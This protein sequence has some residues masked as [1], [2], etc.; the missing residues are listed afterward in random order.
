MRDKTS[1]HFV[2][3]IG[4][5]NTGG[6]GRVALYLACGL[7][8][9]G[10]SATCIS[11]RQG[12]N[13]DGFLELLDLGSRHR[14]IGSFITLGRLISYIRR[15][16]PSVLHVHGPESLVVAALAIIGARHEPQLWFTWHNSEGVFDGSGPRKWLICWAVRRSD[17]LFGASS[18]IVNCMRGVLGDLPR[19]EVFR[20]G[21]P[22]VEPTTGMQAN[23]PVICWCGRMVPSKDPQALLRAAAALKREGFLFRV[24]LAGD[25]PA[26]LAWFMEDTKSLAAKLGIADIVEFPGWVDDVSALIGRSAIGVQTSHTEGLSMTLLEQ[27]MAGLAVVATDVGDTSVAVKDNKSGYVVPIKDDM[28]LVDRLR[29][30]LESPQ[31]RALIGTAARQRAI[32]SFSLECMALQAQ[33]TYE[34]I[35]A[36]RKQ[37]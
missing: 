23:E 13:A 17:I 29:R 37:V 34:R 18:N 25:A 9:L 5:F 33:E 27:M 15:K 10:S 1:K 24:V 11:L 6:T 22:V 8:S 32:A 14:M 2:E 7:K 20:N 3:V 35:A 4:N 30:L 19:I 26:H 31:H 28:A 21:V 12:K 16:R 36:Q